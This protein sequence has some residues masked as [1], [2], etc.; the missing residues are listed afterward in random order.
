MPNLYSEEDKAVTERRHSRKRKTPISPI[1]KI[2]IVVLAAA[3]VFS[4]VQYLIKRQNLMAKKEALLESIREQEDLSKLYTEELEKVG[5][6]EYY[7]YMARKN[8]GYIYPDEK[9]LIVTEDSST[10]PQP[11]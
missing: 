6:P 9:I 7:E 5:T 1:Y 4:T 10:E 11:E 8:L 3:F 2:V